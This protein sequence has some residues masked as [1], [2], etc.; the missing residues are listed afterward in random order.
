M[1]KPLDRISEAYYNKMGEEF[2]KKTRERIHWIC[3]EAKGEYI[4]DVGCSQGI[5]SIL[6]GREGKKVLGIDLNKESIEFAKKEL[7]KESEITKKY[8]DF[9]IANFMDY[10]FKDKKFDSIIMAEILEHLTDPERFIEKA[11]KLLKDDGRLIVTVPFGINE[12]IDHKKSYYLFDMF[13]MLSKQYKIVKLQ[14]LG[15][16]I[17][18]V[19][20]IKHEDTKQE[21]PQIYIKKLE[22]SFYFIERENLNKIMKL[23][24]MLNETKGRLQEIKKISEDKEK[25][26]KFK[27]EKLNGENKKLLELIENYKE[28]LQET[29]K[30]SEDR[31]KELKFKTEKLNGENKKLLELIENYKEELQEIKKIS[32]DREKELKFKTEKLNEE[33]KKLSV[34]IESYKKEIQEIKKIYEKRENELFDNIETLENEKKELLNKIQHINKDNE[35]LKNNLLE[36]ISSEEDILLRYKELLSKHSELNRNYNNIIKKYHSLSNSKLGK[37]TLKYWATRKKLFRKI[38]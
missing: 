1:E 2:G 8:V 19:C 36:H 34:Q 17:A 11:Y 13:E 12:Y 15:N 30:I 35:N 31:E 16:W 22:E 37:L 18:F 3:S 38:K 23:S 26:L 32:E 5:A 6:L 25:E 14:I 33:N 7:E 4:L 10:D 20:I 21:I 27:T 9:Q 24:S 28:E 29:K